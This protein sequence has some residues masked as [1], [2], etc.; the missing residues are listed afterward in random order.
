MKRVLFTFAVAVSIAA[1]LFAGEPTV[2]ADGLGA[3]AGL[4]EYVTK[5]MNQWQVPGLAIA[6]VKD[7]RV[8]HARGFGVRKL[9]ERKPVTADTLFPIC[10]CTK[11]FTATAVGVLVDEKKLDWD[12]PVQKHLPEFELF[13]PFMTR[14]VTLRDLLAHR[15]GLELGNKLW[16]KNEF[17]PDDIIRRMRFLLP[18]HSFRSRFSYNNLTYLVAGKVVERA[19]GKTWGEFI[20]ARILQPAE[21]LATTTSFPT[22]SKIAWPHAELERKLQAIELE[23]T[24]NESVAPAGTMWS[25]VGDMTNWIRL[26]LASGRFGE[27]Q[28]LQSGTLDEMHTPHIV[29]P[30]YGKG[31]TYPKQNFRSCGM[32]W[33]V[34]DYHGRKLVWHSGTGNGFV[35]W[36]ALLPEE[37]IGFVIL[38]NAHQTGINFALHHRILDAF[39]GRPAKDWSSIVK[40]DY[41]T[42]WKKMLSDA[43]TAHEARRRLDTRAS[44]KLA[45]YAGVYE[46]EMYGRITIQQKE[47]GLEL[48][49]GPRHIGPLR[50]WQDNTFQANFS[51]PMLEGWHVT[52]LINKDETI[53][54]LRAVEAAWAPEWHGET[55]DLGVFERQSD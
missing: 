51:N 31:T 16:S 27:R 11:S 52:F 40:N 15:T 25:N 12:D 45:Q 48:R 36:V 54:S 7:G 17:T 55:A 23:R 42:G 28:V 20:K 9:G 44:L 18:K 35:A 4:D 10:S 47:Q 8:V 19:S 29:I 53:E 43:K 6:V 13:D 32:G 38:A 5:T 50:H 22:E 34:E 3:L 49:F 2:A 37:K 41:A 24:Y 21:M 30:A 33:F 26:H 46:S 1:R 14:E 39:L